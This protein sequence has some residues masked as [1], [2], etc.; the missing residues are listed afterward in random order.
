MPISTISSKGQI[1]VPARVRRLL[2]LKPNDRVTIESGGNAIIIRKAADFFEL[3][4]FL[5]KAL[6]IQEEKRSMQQK[7]SAHVRGVE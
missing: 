6:P 3:K 1:T 5:G 4:G 2:N 7:A